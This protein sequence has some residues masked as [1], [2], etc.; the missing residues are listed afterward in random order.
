MDRRLACLFEVRPSHVRL[1]QVLRR[2]PAYAINTDG[3]ELSAGYGPCGL[4]EHRQSLN[5]GPIL[6]RQGGFHQVPKLPCAELPRIFRE[7]VSVDLAELA[8]NDGGLTRPSQRDQAVGLLPRIGWV[9]PLERVLHPP[10]LHQ[11][12]YADHPQRG[13]PRDR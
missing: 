7:P 12:R 1:A 8:Q 5:E 11:D 4:H 2:E 10:K 9:A 13:A 3:V 6:K